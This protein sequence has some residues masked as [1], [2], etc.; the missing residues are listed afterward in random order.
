MYQLANIRGCFRAKEHIGRTDLRKFANA[1]LH[2]RI[3]LLE[4]CIAFFYAHD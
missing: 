4:C 3:K 1:Y 2:V